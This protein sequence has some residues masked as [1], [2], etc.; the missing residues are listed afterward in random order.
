MLRR[1][2]QRAY[3]QYRASYDLMRHYPTFSV[4]LH[5]L[6][7]LLLMYLFCPRT[8]VV[9]AVYYPL[10]YGGMAFMAYGLVRVVVLRERA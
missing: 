4:P 2:R 8:P 9:V 3:I 1:L 7:V 6:L 10:A 5:I